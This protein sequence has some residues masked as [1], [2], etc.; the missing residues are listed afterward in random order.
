MSEDG[1]TCFQFEFRGVCV[2]ISGERS[3]VD[4][5][6]QVLMRD[7]ESAKRGAEEHSGP[8]VVPEEE[9]LVWVH[10][11]SQMMHKIYLAE[12][13]SLARGLLGR[14]IDPSWI[15]TVY[16]DKGAFDRLLAGFD[17]DRTLWA[18]LTPEGRRTINQLDPL[19]G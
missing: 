9:P 10:R 7:M 16:A 6:Y 3:Y 13:R 8:V 15:D 19:K 2:E 5:M 14:V 17:G 18:E 11:C 1:L 4:E 12:V